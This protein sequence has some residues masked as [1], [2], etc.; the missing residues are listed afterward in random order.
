LVLPVGKLALAQFLEEI[1][2]LTEI[3]GRIVQVERAGHTF[4]LIALPHPSGAS[5]WH[6][7]DPGKTLTRK[8]LQLIRNHDAWISRSQ[9][10]VKRAR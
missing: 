3:V 1:P 7:I 9:C 8:A 10:A 5:P 2:P 6:R 4:D